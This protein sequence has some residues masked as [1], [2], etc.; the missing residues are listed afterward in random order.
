MKDIRRDI[1][2]F[3]LHFPVGVVAFFLTLWKPSIGITFTF[4][5][6]TYEIMN[7]WRK[8]D[9]SYKDVYGF[10]FGY[11]IPACFVLIWLFLKAMEAS[12]SQPPFFSLPLI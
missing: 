2:G 4:I 7:D 1:W 12:L 5:F 8:K 11:G 3:L 10:A 9:H 6:L